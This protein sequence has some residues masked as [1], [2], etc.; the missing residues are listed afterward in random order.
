MGPKKF[1]KEQKDSQHPTTLTFI[2]LREVINELSYDFRYVDEKYKKCYP[3]TMH[4]FV[5][6]S[7]VWQ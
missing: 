4:N 5:E 2:V 7:L 1:V 6:I 3:Q